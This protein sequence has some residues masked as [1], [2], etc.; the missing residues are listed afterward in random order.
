MS[1]FSSEQLEHEWK[2]LLLGV[3]PAI[4]SQIQILIKQHANDMA[5]HF[6]SYMLQ[7]PVA[8]Q[9]LSHDQVKT[10]L[11][12]S[13]QNWLTTI[14]S[15]APEDDLKAVVALQVKVGEVHAR[16]DL[17]VHIVLRGA[18]GLKNRF[19]QLLSASDAL[20]DAQRAQ[21]FQLSFSIIDLAIEIMSQAYSGFHDR[22]ARAEES[23]RLFSVAQN[24]VSEREKQRAALLDWENQIMFEYAIG[25]SGSALPALG[26]S[27]FGLWF[28][29]KGAHAFQGAVETDEILE[30]IKKVDQVLLEQFQTQAEPNQQDRVLQLRELHVHAKAIAFHL[31]N[32]F[33]Q[34][35]ELEAGRDVLTRL[36][37]RKYL[38]AVLNKE[39]QYARRSASVFG[40]AVIDIDYFKRVNDQYGHDAGDAVLQQVAAILNNSARGSDYVFRLGGEEFLIVLVDVKKDGA[41]GMLQ[42]LRQAIQNEVFRLPQG[43]T[44]RLS[45]SIGLAFYNGHPDYQQILHRADTGL[46]KAKESG[47]N[48]VVV[49]DM[50]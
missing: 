2:S 50:S 21:I 16:I 22:N 29:H 39:V 24:L 47:R 4:L 19:H 37:S 46:Y 43:Q 42:S 41:L 18:R 14:F 27:E 15:I 30:S 5:T 8:S 34:H 32:L 10:R 35:N 33:E 36:L 45:V 48:Q 44:V 25:H 40:L 38:P 49:V 9:F 20:D 11:H 3:S 7:D 12:N 1:R 31:D 17:P 6:Y 13:M 26:T 28:R 23:Y